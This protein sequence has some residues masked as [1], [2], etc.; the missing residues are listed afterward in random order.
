MSIN[1]FA[2]FMSNIPRKYIPKVEECLHNAV[3]VLGDPNITSEQHDEVNSDL[4]QLQS[5]IGF[6]AVNA[7]RE[8]LRQRLMGIYIDKGY[9]KEEA[10]NMLT[11]RITQIVQLAEK[12]RKIIQDAGMSLAGKAVALFTGIALTAGVV[13][14]GIAKGNDAEYLSKDIQ[15]KVENSKIIEEFYNEVKKYNDAMRN[16]TISKEEFRNFTSKIAEPNLS[17]SLP[18]T[19][20]SMASIPVVIEVKQDDETTTIN[21][22]VGNVYSALPN[23]VQRNWETATSN[24][25]RSEPAWRGLFGNRTVSISIPDGSAGISVSGF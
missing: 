20:A 7:L 19:M 13:V 24:Y 14:L 12:K 6:D 4:D 22:T 5:K 18:P 25:Q 21:S 10:K 3:K 8:E 1:D 2:H 16:L 15:S 23:Q 11:P 17:A 9:T